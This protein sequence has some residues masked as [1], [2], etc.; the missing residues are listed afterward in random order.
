MWCSSNLKESEMPSIKSPSY[1]S[2]S[3]CDLC[4]RRALPRVGGLQT[5]GGLATFGDCRHKEVKS[6]WGDEIE[7]PSL[8]NLYIG[9]PL[10]R[11]HWHQHVTLPNGILK[12]AYLSDVRVSGGCTPYAWQVT[13]GALPAGITTK[14]S[15]NT[16]SVTLAGTPSKVATYSFTI[17]ARACNGHIAR[18]S[19]K[20]VIQAAADHVVDLKWEPSSSADVVGYNIYRGPEGKSWR[21]INS[22]HAA[23]TMYSDSTV[24]DK[25]TY[26]YAAI[27]VDVKG[28]E[29][30][31]SNI[32]KSSIP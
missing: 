27:A 3:R 19:Y 6:I 18:A 23:S 16:S 21:K 10:S 24:A 14:K 4:D 22:S 8:H 9:L 7:N 5:F 26:H 2:L 31:K 28:S 20:V 29:S 17:S 13:S 30:Q 12:D 1:R 15:S 25:S 11:K 32:A